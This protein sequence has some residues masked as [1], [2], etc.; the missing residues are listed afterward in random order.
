MN[1]LLRRTHRAKKSQSIWTT[2]LE[3]DDQNQ[4]EPVGHGSSRNF[5][6]SFPTDQLVRLFVD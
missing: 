4:R 2:N 5:F 1:P 3:D 6:T